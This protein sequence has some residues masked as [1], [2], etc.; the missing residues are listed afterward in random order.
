[1]ISL[2]LGTHR[3]ATYKELSSE[4][5]VFEFNIFLLRISG[6]T[7]YEQMRAKKSKSKTIL[8]LQA[9]KLEMTVI[10]ISLTEMLKE[11]AL[12][13]ENKVESC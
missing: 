7:F 3:Q 8:T 11:E 12:F 10:Q 13:P 6:K 4:R 9:M 5:T 1:M 2:S